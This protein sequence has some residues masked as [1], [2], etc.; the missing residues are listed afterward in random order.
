MMAILYSNADIVTTRL[1]QVQKADLVAVSNLTLSGEQ[2]IDGVL[3]STSTVLCT[4]QTTSAQNGVY[5]TSGGAW[6]RTTALDSDSDLS[7]W[8]GRSIE[9]QVSNAGDAYGLTGGGVSLGG[10]LRY[11]IVPG[12]AAT[13]LGTDPLAWEVVPGKYALLDLTVA[14]TFS[15]LNVTNIP[16]IPGATL[17]TE[18]FVQATGTNPATSPHI[19]GTGGST[20]MT[21]GNYQYVRFTS[22]GPSPDPIARNSSNMFITPWVADSTESRWSNIRTSLPEYAISGVWKNMNYRNNSSYSADTGDFWFRQDGVVTW[23]N[24]STIDCFGWML[25][26]GNFE[27]GSRLHLWIEVE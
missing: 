10:G 18:L 13:T 14:T 5:T 24:T 17:H 27:M 19:V 25:A 7:D 4:G 16:P 11:R 2:T 3:T 15:T 12:S 22:P 6:S 1:L 21:Q 20:D 9:V 26:P 8:I 23:M